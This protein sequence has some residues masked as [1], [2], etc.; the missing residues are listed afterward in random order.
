MTTTITQPPS[1]RRDLTS[2]QTDENLLARYQALAV[3]Q[4]LGWGSTY[5]KLGRSGQRVR[6]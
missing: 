2:K 5:R 3:G 6:E 4:R 1:R